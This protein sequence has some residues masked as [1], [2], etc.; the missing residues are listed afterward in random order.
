MAINSKDK[1]NIIKLFGNEE[2]CFYQLG[3]KD[4][5]QAKITAHNIQN[6][7]ST[8]WKTINKVAHKAI[9]ELLSR[10]LLNN[11]CQRL[12]A[13]CEGANISYTELSYSLFIPE[14][15]SFLG[16]WLPKINAL[17]FGCSSFFSLDENNNPIHTRI[18][19]FPL[20]E[21]YDKHERII[22][23]SYNDMIPTISFT[24]AGL[25]F[26]GLTSMNEA[27]LTLAIHQKF[28]TE[29]NQ[30]GTSIFMLAHELIHSCSNVDEAKEFLESSQTVTTWNFNLM[31][32]RGKVL[33][34]DLMGKESICK[35]YDLH[36]TKSIY[37]NNELLKTSDQSEMPLSIDFYNTSRRDSANKYLDKIT[38]VSQ[39]KIIKTCATPIKSKK[40]SISPST[41]ATMACVSFNPSDEKIMYIPGEAPKVFNGNIISLT[42]LWS[43]KIKENN[44]QTKST[45]YNDQMKKGMRQLSL[46]QFHFDSSDFHECYHC[47]QMAHDT[48]EGLP[49]AHLASFYFIIVQYIHEGHETVLRQIQ[50]DLQEIFNKL[51]D[52]L[53]DIAKVIDQRLSILSSG[54][55][56]INHQIQNIE[57]ANR[58]EQETKH[59]KIIHLAL[60]KM[61]FIH[62]D[63]VDVI[64]A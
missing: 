9:S 40:I 18:L 24:T 36:K 10:A 38:N 55:E 28:S 6:L 13:Y 43:K 61:T 39:D 27:G 44:T 14:I 53:K 63:I 19:D 59:N 23:A 12:R 2:E 29:F 26:S 30:E 11:D 51:P 42:D 50:Y 22:K 31:D 37:I 57:L 49:L 32:N 20:K 17:Q 8:P 47:L 58:Y 33:E 52:Y 25:P 3:L 62:I 4:Q 1:L 48:L 34:M 16:L 7:V 60:K 46:A 15:C 45:A 54:P 21:T 56:L 5:E 64:F 35:E 41:I